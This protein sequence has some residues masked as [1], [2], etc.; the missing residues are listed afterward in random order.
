MPSILAT[1]RDGGRHA[2]LQR[3]NGAPPVRR[4]HRIDVSAGRRIAR[5]SWLGAEGEL[6]DDPTRGRVHH[7]NRIRP[8]QLLAYR[9]RAPAGAA[10]SPLDPAPRDATM[11]TAVTA[12]ASRRAVALDAQACESIRPRREAGDAAPGRKWPR[13]GRLPDARRAPSP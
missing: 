5:A 6:A 1:H 11:A 12:D 13:A 10:A 4:G 8:V 2:L 3:Y 7:P 9:R